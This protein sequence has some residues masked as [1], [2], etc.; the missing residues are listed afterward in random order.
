MTLISFQKVYLS[1]S[2]LILNSEFK[3]ISFFLFK[4]IYLELQVYSHKSFIRVILSMY[5]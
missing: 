5:T 1:K 4:E 2:G 3:T